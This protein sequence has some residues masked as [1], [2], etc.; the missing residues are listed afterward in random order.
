MANNL[1]NRSFLAGFFLLVVTAIGTS[2][3]YLL[4]YLAH[5]RPLWALGDCL[6]MTIITLTTVGLGEILDVANVP[7]AR[8]FT[9]FILLAAWV[10]PLALFRP[11]PPSW[12][13]ANLPM[14]S[15]EKRWRSRFVSFPAISLSA[16]WGASAVP[17]WRSCTGTIR[18][19]WSLI[20]MNSGSGNYRSNPAIFRR[21]LGMQPMRDIWR[22]R[23]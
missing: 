17:S 20:P 18:L 2:G 23:W 11:S 9:V 13:K 6:S 12:S 16:G 19:L 22:R 7:G 1:K 4:S 8:L 15:G 14:C 5:G 3:Y 21:W 10:L